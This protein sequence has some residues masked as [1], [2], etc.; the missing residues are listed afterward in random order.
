M[1]KIEIAKRVTSVVVG[2]GTSAVVNGIIKTNV[3]VSNIP[4]KVAVFATSVVI[5]SMASKAA[6]QH[7]DEMIDDIVKQWNE[8]TKTE[9]K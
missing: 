1:N 5:G 8:I 9:S 3:P 4:M 7:S 6:V 2:I